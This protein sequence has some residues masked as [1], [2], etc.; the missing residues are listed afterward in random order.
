MVGRE[1]IEHS[2]PKDLVYSQAEGPPSS[3]PWYSRWDSNPQQAGL[4]SAASAVGPREHGV[5][6]GSRTFCPSFAGKA[7]NPLAGT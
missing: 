4:K 2:F 6:G 3:D 1:R 5:P 7:L